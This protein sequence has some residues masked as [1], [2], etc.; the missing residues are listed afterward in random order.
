MVAGS[1]SSSSQAVG[2]ALCVLITTG[3]S[4]SRRH[5]KGCLSLLAV[6]T[7]H[8]RQG[9]GS[10][11][12][13]AALDFLTAKVRES[14][15][16]SDPPPKEGSLQ[17]GSTFPRFFPGVPE[18]DE[19]ETAYKFFESRGWSFAKEV[20]IDLYRTLTPGK[21]MEFENLTK[22]ALDAGIVFRPP[23]PE[24]DDELYAMEVANFDYATVSHAIPSF[25]RRS[26]NG[27]ET[28]GRAGQRPTP[29]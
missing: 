6:D 11:L 23:K 9:A 29:N 25:G 7:A 13:K 15:H 19:F 28:H 17:L 10:A 3:S 12:H 18:G 14:L 26:P 2:F 21:P 16:L 27:T 24:E 20:A 22:R 8:Q 4:P 5:L 1:S